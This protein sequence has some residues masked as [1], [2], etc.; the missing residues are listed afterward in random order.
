MGKKTKGTARIRYL[1][2]GLMVLIGA[3]CGIWIAEIAESAFPVGQTGGELIFLMLVLFGVFLFAMLFQTVL[4]EAGHLVFGRW[5]GYRFL[6]FRIFSV[7]WIRE[8]GEIR[9]KRY[10]L[11]GTSGQCLMAPPEKKE[12]KFPVVLYNLGGA[13]M[14]LAAAAVFG[15]LGWLTAGIPLLS[16]VWCMAALAGLALALLNGIPMSAAVPNDGYNALCLRRSQSARDSFWIQLKVNEQ[17][18][19]G[20]RLHQMPEEWFTVP[21]D[22]EMKNSMTAVQGVLVCNRLMDACRLEEAAGLMTRLL[23]MDSGIVPLHRNLLLLDL[24]YCELTG[25]NRRE[26]A[27]ALFT[28]ELKKFVRS[29]RQNPSVLRTLYA[30]ALLQERDGA[31]AAALQAQFE[32]IAETYPYPC[33]IQGERVLMVIAMG[34]SGAAPAVAG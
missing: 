28:D 12:G 4:H 18:A 5:I 24:L 16:S 25:E 22:E 3:M 34:K 15:G 17:I 29:M 27:E 21:T 31:K 14:N 30:Y 7:M 6:S 8:N 26:V 11:A 32:K 10:T 20:V 9:R 13:G 19:K 23:Q 1:S 2:L 33:E